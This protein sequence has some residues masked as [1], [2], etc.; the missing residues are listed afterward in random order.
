M[1]VKLEKIRVFIADDNTE[2]REN[3]ANELETEGITV[4]GTAAD[5]ISALKQIASLKPDV[6]LL[7]IVM[8][9]LDGLKKM[10][11][12]MAGL[13]AKPPVEIAGVAVRQQKDYQDGSVVN[14]ADG[15]RETMELSGSNVLRYEMADGTSFIVRP[16]G[17]EPKVKVYIL[18][19][20]ASGQEA[21]DKVAKYA[22]WAETLKN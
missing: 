15:S 21:E 17:T 16:S 8:P 5:G 22:A 7:D 14:V 18:A 20:G 12:L 2:T 10:A 19:N 4:V 3:R 11:D 13:R 6:L 9:G 1:A